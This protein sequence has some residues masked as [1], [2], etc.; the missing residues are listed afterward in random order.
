MPALNAGMD[1]RVVFSPSGF[2]DE[3]ALTLVPLADF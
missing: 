2:R 3:I 1:Y